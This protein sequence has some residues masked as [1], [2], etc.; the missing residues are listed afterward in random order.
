MSVEIQQYTIDIDAQA[1]DDLRLRLAR[2]R[3]PD[4][5]L[6]SGW[7]N[8]TDLAYLRQLV[9]Y[10]LDE[11]DWRAQEARL[12]RLS[13]YRTVI[14]DVPIHFVHERGQGK[15]PLPL[16]MT[17]GWPGSFLEM[18]KILPRLTHP[19]RFGGA[20]ED[21]FDVVIPSVPGFGFSVRPVLGGMNGRKVA[22]LWAALMDG[23][24]YSRY[25]AQGGDIGAGIS[26]WLGYY[27]PQSVAGVHLNFIPGNYEPDPGAQP[28]TAAELAF[29]ERR[30]G[31]WGEEGGY[32]HLQSTRPQTLAYG[33]NDS[34]VGLAAWMLE[35]YRAW[36]DCDGDVE[37][38]FTKDE[39][40][41]Q[42]SLYWFTQ[43]IG[44]SIR[45]YR[46]GRT[47]PVSFHG[48]KPMAVPTA[49]AIFPRELPMP[50]R[51]YAARFY[52]IKRWTEF[53][54]GGHFAAHEVPDLLAA[55]M[56]AFFRTLRG[57]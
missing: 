14:D 22:G 44:S 15:N 28:L 36:S 3:W 25:G 43:T 5:M 17:H 27:H 6:G 30:T 18:E 1:I 20:E 4:E 57:A 11:F 47:N 26:T 32:S 52:D 23:L 35:K 42:I 37:V 10:W 24:G 2:T 39:L 54:R 12:N 7:R 31:W 53:E 29:L 19:D 13:H 8:G 46:E 16:I 48:L 34:P 33:L 38:S 40:L 50:P 45:Y 9:E 55:D 56:R 41:T 49:V 21:A 51:E